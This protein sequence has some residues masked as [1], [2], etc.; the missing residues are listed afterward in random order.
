MTSPTPSSQR[1]DLRRSP[2]KDGI[3]G[4]PLQLAPVHLA[5]LSGVKGPSSSGGY[6]PR[7]RQVVQ[8]MHIGPPTE[9]DFR[10]TNGLMKC[11]NALAPL[12]APED[13]SAKHLVISELQRVADQWMRETFPDKPEA[14]ATLL[15]GGS[16]HLKVGQ[17]D[18][19][20]DIVA[21]LPNFVTSEVFFDSL[22]KYLQSMPSVS[23]LVAMTKATAPILAF[24]LNGV[25]IDLLFA[26][27]TQDIVPKNLPIH[28]D[29]I[30]AGM[31]ATSIR[32]I[33][34]PR[35]AS[36]ILELVPN[37]SA[38]RSCLRI[39]RLW[40][41]RRGL[42]SNKAGFLGGISWTILVAFICQMFP[43][44]T[45]SSVV[46]RFFSVLSTWNWPT[47]I[48]L[49]KPYDCSAVDNC[50][51]WSPQNN[52]HDRGHLMPIITPGFPAV[53]S[54]V[55][56]NVST[57]RILQEELERGKYIMDDMLAKGLSSPAVWQKLFAP[58]EFLVRYDHYLVIEL[59]A[60]S[61]DE[62]SEWS[63]YVSSRTRKLVETLEHTSPIQSVHP[64]PDLIK[65]Q[66]DSGD[67]TSGHYFIGYTVDPLATRSTPATGVQGDRDIAAT[68]VTS[69]ARYFSATEL[70]TFEERKEGMTATITYARW[71]DLPEEVFP[72]GRTVAAG[73][74]AR[75]IL[76]RAHTSNITLGLRR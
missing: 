44:A 21:L 64:Y 14:T 70:E 20:L 47:P 3:V 22:H 26:R 43:K 74:R 55:N 65:R 24:Q 32:S 62:M 59:R 48:L 30:L 42:Y 6:A 49:S 9:Y 11:L 67:C 75:Y 35:V 72:S 38:F 50:I 13:L 18:S 25:R 54:S 76:Q 45:I 2:N 66:T 8:P 56:V 33:S 39:I 51:Q 34:I 63:N 61:D 5:A 19:D 41:K 15:L 69:A 12:P 37:G 16:W 58:S 40:A 23:K 36:L 53:N 28:S 73:E 17:A 27:Y 7:L 60:N 4:S 71:Q 31:D 1:V 52:H 68:C 57:L 46:H 29:R 10:N